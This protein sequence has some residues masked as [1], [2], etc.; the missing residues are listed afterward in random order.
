MRS[1]IPSL[2]LP[3]KNEKKKITVPGFRKQYG[4]V[5][6]SNTLVPIS[7]LLDFCISSF[8]VTVIKY[9]DQ[10]QLTEESLLWL[11]VPKEDW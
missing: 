8:S 5:L 1:W 11:M 6:C 10:E 2:V 4:W 3:N 7:V 9:H